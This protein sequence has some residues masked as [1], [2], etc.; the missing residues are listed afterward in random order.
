MRAHRP[1]IQPPKLGIGLGSQYQRQRDGAVEQVA[2]ALLSG[3]LGCPLDVEHVV[4][5]LERDSDS[6]PEAAERL[7]PGLVVA[8]RKRA[9]LAGRREQAGRL[10]LATVQIALDANEAR[11]GVLAL[12][13]LSPCKRE[14]GIGERSDLLQT[15]PAPEQPERTREQK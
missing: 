10:E 9:E 14:T 11:I 15:R 2:A 5:K 12:G 1:K 6:V 3:L 7:G 4:E 13:K 8:R